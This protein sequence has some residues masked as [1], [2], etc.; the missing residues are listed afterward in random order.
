MFFPTG[1]RALGFSWKWHSFPS[2]THSTA[3]YKSSRLI[4]PAGLPSSPPPIPLA[5]FTT[6]A[7]FSC[8]SILRITTG[9]TFTLEARKSLVTFCLSLKVSIQIST[10]TAMVKRLEICIN[11]LLSCSALILFPHHRILIAQAV[12]RALKALI[13]HKTHIV[14]L[15]HIH[16]ADIGLIILVI[17]IKG[18]GVAV[19]PLFFHSVP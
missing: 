11:S 1:Q 14:V 19:C 17:G 10:W 18:A 5:T 4:Y 13:G 7:A 2:S 6:P 15:I 3:R 9:F 12:V 16:I 8:W